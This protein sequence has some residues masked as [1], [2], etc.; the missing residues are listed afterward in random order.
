M[1]TDKALVY[2]QLKSQKIDSAI[3]KFS[4][5]LLSNSK[6]VKLI[7][8][9]VNH[10]E[11]AKKNQFKKI[12]NDKIGELYLDENTIYEH[13]YWQNGFEGSNSYGEWLEYREIEYLIFP[14][15]IDSKNNIQNLEE[16]QLIIEKIGHFSLELDTDELKLICYKI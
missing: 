13:D 7:N 6:W 11:K 10:I 9:L 1:R 5:P 3:S 12:Q 16:I 4:Q 8:G 15:I 14:K 2:D